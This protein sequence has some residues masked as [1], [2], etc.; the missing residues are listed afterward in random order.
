MTWIIPSGHIVLRIPILFGS[1]EYLGESA[2]T[3]LVELLFKKDPKSISD[4]EIRYPSHV[5]DIAGICCSL[6][7]LK[8]LGQNIQGKRN[9]KQ[10]C[11]AFC[12]V[13]TLFFMPRNL[14]LGR[15]RSHDEVRNGRLNGKGF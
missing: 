11:N 10:N 6:L 14:S 8:L 3:C 15:Q 12:K 7:E 1:V 5:N 4:Y 13:N 9:L 2:V